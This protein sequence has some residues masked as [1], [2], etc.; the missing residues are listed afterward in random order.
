MM[1]PSIRPTQ[2]SLALELGVSRQTLSNVLNHPEVVAPET[3]R[4]VED[5]MKASGYRLTEAGRALRTRRS[6]AIALRLH[7]VV[8]GIN[9]E[10]LDRFFHA[11]TECAQRSGYRIN[12]F[13][14]H[15]PN[16]E[17]DTLIGMYQTG[18]IDGAVLIDSALHDPRPVQLT[19]AG[20]PFVVFGRPWG[21][22]SASHSWVDVDGR[23]GLFQATTHLRKAGHD[24]IGFIGWPTDSAVGEDRREGWLLAGGDQSLQVLT[25][26]NVRDGFAAAQELRARGATA[27]VCVSDGLALGALP[28]FTA[29]VQRGAELPVIGFDNTPVA[30]AIGLSSLSQPVEEVAALLVGEVIDRIS[31][32]GVQSPKG[33][34][35]GPSLE[36][37]HWESIVGTYPQGKDKE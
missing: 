29:G 5:A 16:Q 25:E 27:L 36:L 31:A 12:L 10:V 30:R 3:R 23:A 8:D 7:P 9:G 11:V 37:R 22:A 2:A 6:G 19:D 21:E 15:G 20:L 24:A 18:V 28:V 1:A 14:A 13:T 33:T 32:S 4:R 35:L 34:L 26:N 17:I